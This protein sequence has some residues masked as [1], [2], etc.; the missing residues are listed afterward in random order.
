MKPLF[1]SLAIFIYSSLFLIGIGALFTRFDEFL[2]TFPYFFNLKGALIYAIVLTLVKIIHEFS[3]AYTA[4][5]YGVRVPAMGIALLV[6]WPVLFTDVTDGWRLSQRRHRLAISLAGIIAECIIAGLCTFGWAFSSPGLLQSLFFV[7]ASA[8]WIS[9]NLLNANPAMRFD[10]YY[11]LIDLWGVDNLRPRAFAVTRCK[12]REWFLGLTTPQQEKNLSTRR[13]Y[14]MVA[15][16]L[17]TWIYRLFLY[18]AIALFVYI[19]FTKALGIFLFF[20]EIS[21]FMVWPVVSEMKA[22]IALRG[23]F[24]KNLRVLLT[25]LGFAALF[26]WFALPLPRTEVFSA[27]TIP[28]QEQILYVPR[29]AI[30]EEIFVTRNQKIIKGQPIIRLVSKELDHET[31]VLLLESKVLA[32]KIKILGLEDEDRAYIPEN[33]RELEAIKAKRK[34]V[35]AHIHEM[36]LLSELDG[37]LFFWDENLRANQAVSKDKIL[38]KIADT[39]TPAVVCFV[40]ESLLHTVREGQDVEFVLAST[41]ETFKGTIESISPIRENKLD[42]PALAS[43][44]NGNLPVV[45]DSEENLLLVESYYP[46]RITL[47]RPSDKLLFGQVGNVRVQGPRRSLLVTTIKSLTRLLWKESGI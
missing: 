2:H 28:V 47:D 23:Y 11:I 3:H 9:T 6:L 7:I 30:I 22:L 26:I 37:Q 40:P 43:K 27:I 24:K 19:S 15:Y 38:G 16:S 4:A 25:S 46:V 21:I 12:L 33:K 42:Y 34:G 8:G 5:H 39:N 35:A 36:A 44:Y 20:F 10:G 29:D 41:H 45:E 14:G 1:S 13:M 18:T 32:R 17:Y 31:K